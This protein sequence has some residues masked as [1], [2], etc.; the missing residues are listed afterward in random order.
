MN[1]CGCNNGY[2]WDCWPWLLLSF[3]TFRFPPLLSADFLSDF[4]SID[5]SLPSFFFFFFFALGIT[6]DTKLSTE[7]D[8]ESVNGYG[9][10]ISTHEEPSNYDG[11]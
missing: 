4:C 10:K 3:H 11:S 9:S 8:I 7:R 2:L 6:W 5:A 1:R